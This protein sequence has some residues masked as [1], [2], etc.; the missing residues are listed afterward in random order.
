[1]QARVKAS[2]IAIAGI[3]NPRSP[4]TWSGTP[5]RLCQAFEAIDRLGPLYDAER[6]AAWPIPWLARGAARLYYLNSRESSRGVLTRFLRAKGLEAFLEQHQPRH[7]LHIGSLALPLRKQNTQTTHHL[8]CDTTWHLWMRYSTD[9]YRIQSRLIEDAER[10]EREAYNQ[11]AR[12]FTISQHAKRGLIE[13]YG[14]SSEK[15]IVVGTGRGGIVPYRGKK[16]Y[17]GGRVLFVAKDRFIDKGGEL[18]V[19]GFQLAVAKN[20]SLHLIL[21]G[22]EKYDRFAQIHPNIRAH[23]FVSLE[24]L[25]QLFNEA[26][27]FAMPALNE[28]WGLVYL[29]ALSCRTPVLGLARNALPEITLNGR[30]GFCVKEPTAESISDALLFAFSNPDRLASMG[31]SGQEYCLSEFTWEQTVSRIVDVIDKVLEA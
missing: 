29:E 20:P 28:P 25:Q 14:V 13:H 9:V 23:G 8:F 4:A 6:Y 3:G 1:M 22:D 5:N 17:A 26:A 16:D 21:V 7:I 27:L 2:K 12:I 15:I 30:H 18:L 24:A 11:M 19:K 31:W 10:L